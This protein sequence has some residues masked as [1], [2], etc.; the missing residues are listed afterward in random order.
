MA[1]LQKAGGE[2]YAADCRAG[3]PADARRAQAGRRSRRHAAV[4]L[5]GELQQRLHRAPSTSPTR[6]ARSSCC[7]ARRCSRRMLTPILDYASLPRWKFPFAPHD[8]GTYPQAN[9][10]VYGGGERTEEN[11]MPVEESGNMLI[12]MAALAQ[13]EGNADFAAEVLAAADQVGRVSR[14]TKASTRRTSSDRRLRR[15]PRAQREPVD[16]GDPRARRLR[17]ARRHDR[18]RRGRD[19][20]PQRWC[21]DSPRNGPAGRRWRALPAGVRQARHVEPEVQPGLG[22]A[23][24]PR[25]CSR[26]TVART[27]IAYLQDA[28]RTPYGLPLDNRERYTKLDWIV[29]TA[30]LADSP[31]DFAAFI[32]PVVQLPERV[33]EPR[34]DDRLVLDPRRQAARVSGPLGGR[35]RVHQD[36]GGARDVEEVC[37][38]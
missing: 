13:I 23:A 31:A 37:E 2:H 8:L 10:Q 32:D 3:L 29:W 1:D 20:L 36:V 9:G 6:A 28:C 30:T 38:K 14:R 21:A 25:T 33:A 17:Q 26:P 12:M 4:L 11:Q 5:E 27:E 35:R 24:R 15:P 22:Q 34:P 7:S 19:G 18:P 16:Q